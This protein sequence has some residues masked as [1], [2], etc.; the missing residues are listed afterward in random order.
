VD[1]IG[2]YRCLRTWTQPR[3]EQS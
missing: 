3:S 1:N 2:R